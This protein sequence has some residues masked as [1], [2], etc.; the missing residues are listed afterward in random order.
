MQIVPVSLCRH[1]SKTGSQA[2]LNTDESHHVLAVIFWASFSERHEAQQTCYI[3][4]G[5]VVRCG[6]AL[7]SFVSLQQCFFSGARVFIG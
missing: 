4:T 2:T 6:W 1:G 3:D 5:A 7:V